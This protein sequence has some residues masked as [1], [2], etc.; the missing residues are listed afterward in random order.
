M[1]TL[2]VYWDVYFEQYLLQ[3][4]DSIAQIIYRWNSVAISLNLLPSYFT[5]IMDKY[6]FNENYKFITS[7][8]V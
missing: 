3:S 2:S 5:I 7:I 4:N 8:E 6:S 1:S